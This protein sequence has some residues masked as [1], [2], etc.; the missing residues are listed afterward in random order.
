MIIV[1]EGI[2]A[3][4][5]TT[6]CRQHASEFLVQESYPELRPDRNADARGAALLWTDWNVR[7][8]SEAVEIEC[9]Q[10]RAVCDTDPLK[11]HYIWG[12]WQIGEAPESHWRYQMKATRNALQKCELGFAD[13][14]LVKRI[15]PRVARQQREQDTIK[16]RS[17]FDLHARLQAS[18]HVW[19][20]TLAIMLPRRV[21]WALPDNL[22][23]TA[24]IDSP[25]E[26]RYD[27]EVFDRLIAGLPRASYGS[28][29]GRI[30][31]GCS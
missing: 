20:E 24:T 15:D 13:L 3:A 6:W 30:H 2:S 27:V 23:A 17:N 25:S 28:K 9:E 16:M 22:P 4:G 10:E 14:Y 5:K 29:A 19:Y 18:L 21:E 7:R 8:W 26:Y 31:A 12:L 1:V 11:L